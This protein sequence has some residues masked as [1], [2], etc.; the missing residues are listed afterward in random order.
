[1]NSGPRQGSK[2]QAQTLRRRQSLSRASTGIASR[3]APRLRRP[4]QQA[5]PSTRRKLQP[6]VPPPFSP[7]ALATR[8]RPSRP[9]QAAGSPRTRMIL[10][11]LL[12]RS[13]CPARA[14]RVERPPTST[15][16][17]RTSRGRTP[18]PILMIWSEAPIKDASTTTSSNNRCLSSSTKS[19]LQTRLQV[20]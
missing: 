20:C 4:R 1:M 3:L 2:R 17:S 5:A 7:R 11:L 14:L 6:L 12:R 18:I 13:R 10:V 8:W 19:P 15:T 9:R 16:C